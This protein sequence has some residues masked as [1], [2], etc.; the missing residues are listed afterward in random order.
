[1]RH[2]DPDFMRECLLLTE[3]ADGR[4]DASAND[5]A[6]LFDCTR[7]S[8]GKPEIRSMQFPKGMDSH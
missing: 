7:V 1:M 8:Q 6:C 2:S 3:A 5:Y 4:S